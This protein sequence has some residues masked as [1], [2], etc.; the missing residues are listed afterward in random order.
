MITAEPK[1]TVP[2]LCVPVHYPLGVPL[3]RELGNY[4]WVFLAR[5]PLLFFKGAKHGGILARILTDG[6]VVLLTCT[7][8]G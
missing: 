3:D 6:L 2:A 4:Q 1:Q 8:D 5:V 7:R